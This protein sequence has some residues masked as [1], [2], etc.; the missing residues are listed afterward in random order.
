MKNSL[1]IGRLAGIRIFL[2]WTF[3]LLLGFV[4]FAEVRRSSSAG[5]VLAAVG[6]V[7]ALFGPLVAAG[8]QTYSKQFTAG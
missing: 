4:V 5:A 7:L 8:G 3:L 6:F 2:H 1:L